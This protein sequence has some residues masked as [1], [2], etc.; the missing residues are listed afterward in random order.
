MICYAG[1]K[2]KGSTITSIQSSITFACLSLLLVGCVS[3]A[4][5]PA[6]SGGAPLTGGGSGNA[7]GGSSTDSSSAT[8]SDGGS[9]NPIGGNSGSSSSPNGGVTG[10]ASSSNPSG[11]VAGSPGT[12]GSSIASNALFT[13]AQGAYWKSST[14]TEVTN[15]VTVIVSDSKTYQ[16]WEG[17]GGAF[18]EKGWSYLSMLSQGDQTQAINLLFGDDGARFNMGRIPIG[19]NDYSIDRYTLDEVSSGTDTSLAS[20]SISRDQTNLIPYIKA[21]LAV[22]S[23]I[24]LWASP[25]TPPTWMKSGPYQN[26]SAFDGGT[27]KSD[28]AT[29]KAFAQYLVKFVQE[30]GNLGMKIEVVAPQNEPTY[31]LSYPSCGWDPATFTK[32]IGQYLGPAFTTAGL[33]TKIMLGTLSNNSSP[34]DTEIANAVL[35]DATAKGYCK[36]VGVQWNMADSGHITAIKSKLGDVPFWLTEHV[37]GNFYWDSAYKTTAPNDQAYGV[38]SWGQIRNAIKNGVSAY[39]AWNMVLDT[40]GNSIDAG[41]PWAQNALLTVDTSAKKLN[42]TPAYYAFR[43]FS[44]FVEVGAQRIDATGPDVVAFK[45]PDG[46][47]VAVMNNTG[48]ASNY[49]VSIGGKRLQFPMPGNGWATLKYKP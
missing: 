6:G 8:R 33:D 35:A 19:A 49:T 45:N 41:K 43:H 10:G 39:N 21:A 32:F 9:G 46:A 2:Q 3:Q 22:K 31:K 5:N 23:N 14:W 48:A 12:G 15:A 34:G 42:L 11:G 40:V 18:N 28:D 24:R 44:Q 13:S 29:L 38:D 17:F 37:C 36:V 27:M 20:F 25:W 47:L 4:S 16:T 30:Y 7:S 1:R 26:S